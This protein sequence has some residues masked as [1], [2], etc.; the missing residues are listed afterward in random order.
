MEP[1]AVGV[2]EDHRGLAVDQLLLL[3]QLGRAQGEVAHVGVGR[4]LVVDVREQE[5]DLVAEEL[6]ELV[7][8]QVAHGGGDAVVLDLQAPDEGQ[9]GPVRQAG[10]GDR[11][12][13]QL[14]PR[15]GAGGL[16]GGSGL[17]GI[18]VLEPAMLRTVMTASVALPHDAELL[19]A[20]PHGVR[21]HA[22]RDAER[23][24]HLGH[25]QALAALAPRQ[26][27]PPDRTLPRR[28]RLAKGTTM[29]EI[30]RLAIAHGGIL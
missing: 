9:P 13:D 19:V 3:D 16:Q 11:V 10:G 29:L 27:H 8:P 1:L 6:R 7:L 22:R 25:G 5:V 30:N 2:R 4:R 18:G 28:E 14:E 26:A 15:D 24:R 23:N 12:L 17:G 20:H 21:D